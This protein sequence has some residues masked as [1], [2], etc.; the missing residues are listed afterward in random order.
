MDVSKNKSS[1][2]IGLNGILINMGESLN[3]LLD[4]GVNGTGAF[5]EG[6]SSGR[7]PV[8]EQRRPG[9]HP[10][11]ARMMWSKDVNKVVMECY[12]KSKP[13]NEN[14]VPIRRCDYRREYQW[15]NWKSM[16]D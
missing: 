1:P 13:V 5:S 15:R 7:C 9:R 12:L 8:G 10:A 4:N 14:G 16:G 3:D 6:A 11:T 2:A